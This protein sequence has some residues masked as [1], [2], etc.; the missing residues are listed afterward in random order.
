M[1][2]YT[3]KLCALAILYWLIGVAVSFALTTGVVCI[4]SI[5]FKFTFTWGIAV[6]V[7][8]TFLFVRALIKVAR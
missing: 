6:G 3:I 1:K 2:L 7:W 5:C 4:L 8:L